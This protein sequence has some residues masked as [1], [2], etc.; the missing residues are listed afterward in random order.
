M[1]GGPRRPVGAVESPSWPPVPRYGHLRSRQA[2][3]GGMSSAAD[4]SEPDEARLGSEA[5]SAQPI[6]TYART[7]W[8]PDPVRQKRA[9]YTVEDLLNLPPDT[10]R[11]EL[12]HG[13]M[14][15]V[16]SPTAFHQNVSRQL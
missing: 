14:Q 2:R 9:D 10:P 1:A 8:R 15:V 12:S 7:P 4:D 3:G 16:P 5:V 6:E 11:V 13:V